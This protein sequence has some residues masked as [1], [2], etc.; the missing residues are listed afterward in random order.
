MMSAL[1]S[2][3]GS[4]TARCTVYRVCDHAHIGHEPLVRGPFEHPPFGLLLL[5]RFDE[6][7]GEFGAVATWVVRH[8]LAVRVHL[9]HAHLQ[10]GRSMDEQPRNTMEA[11]EA[12][13]KRF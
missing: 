6:V 1:P 8:R 11:D 10:N 3:E 12:L 13:T 2:E 7:L 9:A 4:Q 5:A